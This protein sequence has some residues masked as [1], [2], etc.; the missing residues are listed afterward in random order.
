MSATADTEQDPDPG[1]MRTK[2][3][4]IHTIGCQMNVYDA[5]RMAS[6][7]AGL[8]YVPALSAEDADLVMV[9]TC[10]VRDKAEQKAFSIL[11]RLE[12]DKRRR[13]GLIVGVAGCVAQQEGERILGRA[14]HVDIVLG[15]G[16]V[17][18]LAGAVRQVESGRRRV[19]DIGMGVEG[20]SP[21]LP[22]AVESGSVT[23]FVT[24]MRG[25]DN[26]CTYCVVPH[27]RGREVSRPP[28]RI[29]REVESLV[30]HG[31]REVTLLGQNVNS[32]GRKEGMCSFVELLERVNAVSGLQRI[33]FTTSHPKDLTGELIRAFGRLG[34]LCPHIHLPVQSGANRI[35]ARMHRGYTREGY[36]DKVSELRDSCPEI[37]ITS[38][39]IVGFP[40][41]TDLEF[42]ETLDLIG[43]IE[44][45]G[46][47]AFM[48]SD[49]PSAP[50]RHLTDKVPAPIQKQRLHALLEFQEAVTLAKNRALVGTVQEV[51][52]EGPSKRPSAGGTRGRSNAQWSGRT[53][54]NKI[55]NFSGR[56]QFPGDGPRS[57]QVV[58]VRID[59][60][61]AHS[62]RGVAV[63]G[64][65]GAGQ[66]KGEVNHAA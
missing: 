29:I 10:S 34:K 37:A 30:A 65:S 53:P 47:F 5:E 18:R 11:G 57:G 20:E 31:T 27:V 26:F 64:G 8:G 46:I 35:L 60:A 14:P 32:Y 1:L 45:D 36:L 43:R 38:D 63:D 55:V 62:L 24:I 13:P 44:F 12:A 54:G 19:L 9:N 61:L 39:I 59:K 40:G 66:G 17:D 7:L 25:C 50:A 41:E 22:D 58:A 42:E 15:T 28:E 2:T 33:R 3:F 49:R 23:R 52:T 48:Y 4:F 16:A 56:P 21:E 6:G 51:L